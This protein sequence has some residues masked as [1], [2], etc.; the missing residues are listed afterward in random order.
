MA[1]NTTIPIA[2]ARQ[3]PNRWYS[4]RRNG[5]EAARPTAAKTAVPPDPATSA[6]PARKPTWCS[7]CGAIPSTP[8]TAPVTAA[9][10][11]P[12]RR[13]DAGPAGTGRGVTDTVVMARS[14]ATHVATYSACEFGDLLV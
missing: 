3:L 9:R 8:L 13:A 4:R 1:A 12:L 11:V 2:G 7:T 5:T 6:V 10:T 14:L